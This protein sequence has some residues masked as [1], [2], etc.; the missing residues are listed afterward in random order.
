MFFRELVARGFKRLT[1]SLLIL[2]GILL[3]EVIFSDF[4]LRSQEILS[5]SGPL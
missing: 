4:R 2:M 1:S 5:S 3:M